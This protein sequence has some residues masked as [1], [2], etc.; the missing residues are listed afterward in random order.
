MRNLIFR[1]AAGT[2]GLV[3]ATTLS[4]S[5][6]G[7]PG[8]RVSKTFGPAQGVWS[9]AFAATSASDS[10]ST[11]NA[12][13]NFSLVEHWTGSA[14]RQVRVPS[15]LARYANALAIGASSASNVWLF[16]HANVLRWN[17]SAWRLQ[18]IPPWVVR[19]NRAGDYTARPA[20]FSPRSVWVF[21]VGTDSSGNPDHFAARYNG[22]TW[23]RVTL[24]AIPGEIS[25][26]APNDIW[27]HGLTPG[28]RHADVLMRWDSNRW[29][30]V[31]VPAVKPP[32]GAVEFVTGLTATGPRDAWL[33]R[34]IE[35]GSAGAQSLYLMHWNGTRWAQVRFTFPTSLVNAMAQDGH[36]GVWTVDNG[37]A[38]GYHWYLDHLNAGHWTRYTVPAV[39]GRSLLDLTGIT[40]I[41]GTRSLWAAGNLAGP[42]NGNG[43][44][45]LLL[46]F[47]P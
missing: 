4:A 25:V 46:K 16:N 23:T 15:N 24:P 1:V 28:N 26:L 32:P 7:T 30:T 6:A 31:T 8:W 42:P 13:P 21:S 34:G 45:G 36:G 11:W 2:A 17:G 38:P 10:W 47:G 18:Q 9:A 33:V 27:V 29:T 20:V 35:Q 14:W 44:S 37:P 39:P 19:L 40:W 3:L 43:I 22:H 12:Y 5:A 41:P